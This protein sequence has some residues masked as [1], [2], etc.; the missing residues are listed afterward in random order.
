M[1]EKNERENVKGVSHTRIGAGEEIFLG[2]RG[3]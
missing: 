1:Q 2:N 3:K